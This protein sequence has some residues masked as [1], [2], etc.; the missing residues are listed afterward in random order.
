[1]A[2]DSLG[3]IAKSAV[4]YHVILRLADGRHLARDEAERRA[5]ACVMHEQGE[6]RGLFAFR[7][8]DTHAHALT[9]GSR[10]QAGMFAR[11]VEDSLRWRLR[12]GVSFERAQIR[13]LE[14]RWH[15]ERAVPYLFDQER[16]HGVDI[17]PLHEA[18]SLPDLVGMRV[19]GAATTALFR[20]TMPRMKRAE[21]MR[22]FGAVASTA[23]DGR[24]LLDATLAASGLA[25]LG[26]DGRSGAARCAAIHALGGRTSELARLLGADSSTIRRWRHVEPDP[27]LVAAIKLQ[28]A[29]RAGLPR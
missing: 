22:Y 10:E 27:A 7:G 8:A 17:D 16:H 6:G 2:H 28:L 13:P 18:S 11:Y 23:I 29:Y 12:L 14:N 21:L 4:G 25:R 20:I 26:Q 9:V 15:L 5:L 1:M 24:Q 19:I 3:T